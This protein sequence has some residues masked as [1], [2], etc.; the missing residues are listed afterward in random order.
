MKRSLATGLLLLICLAYS[1]ALESGDL[2]KT[3][4]GQSTD[5]NY[6]NPLSVQIIYPNGGEYLHGKVQVQFS[7]ESTVDQ[8]QL[9]A[10]IYTRNE[11]QCTLAQNINL[12]DPAIC[13]DSDNNQATANQCS[14]EIDLKNCYMYPTTFKPIFYLESK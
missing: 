4:M 8:N 3:V 10:N 6:I 14:Y 11:S 13:I 9:L 5:G 1:Y 7:W 12:L 2:N